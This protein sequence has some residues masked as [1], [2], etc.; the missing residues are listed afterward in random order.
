VKRSGYNFWWLNL[1]ERD[2]M[3]DIGLDGRIILRCIFTEWEC[4]D[5]DWI[6]LAQDRDSWWALVNTLMSIRVL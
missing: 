6:D 4:G 2:H 5:T 1:R 3:A